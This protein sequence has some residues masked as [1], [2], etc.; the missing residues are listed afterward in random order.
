VMVFYYLAAFLVMA[1]ILRKNFRQ[2]RIG[3]LSNRG[4][5]GAQTLPPTFRRTFRV[6]WTFSWRTIIY[7]LIATFIASFPLGWTVGFLAAV[8]PRAAYSVIATTVVPVFIDGAVGMYVIYSNILDED[9]SDFRV[10]LLP[11]AESTGTLTD[12]SASANL[13]NS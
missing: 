2:F 8:L 4:G 9:I 11:L 1:Y 3:L 6:W 7:R 13:V 12:P 10:A 5:P